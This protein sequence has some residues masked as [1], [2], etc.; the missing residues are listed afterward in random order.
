MWSAGV[1]FFQMLYGRRPFGHDMT[2]VQRCAGSCSC[3]SD[4]FPARQEAILRNETIIRGARNV[5]FPAKPAVS[6]EVR[7][8]SLRTVRR[9]L[10]SCPQAK[11][12]IRRCLT[13]SQD[14]RPDVLQAASDAYLSFLKTAAKDA[15]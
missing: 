5:D 6:Q 2:Q 15:K 3:I 14:E 7:T 1:I 12:F 8:T 9:R 10:T 11:A 13:Y 4:E